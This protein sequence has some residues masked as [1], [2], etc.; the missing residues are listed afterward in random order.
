[1]QR[2]NKIL[3]AVLFLI[4]FA[5]LMHY[6]KHVVGPYPYSITERDLFC[7]SDKDCRL[8]Y[9]DCGGCC[10]SR[11]DVPVNSE[12]YDRITKWRKSCKSIPANFCDTVDCLSP[13]NYGFRLIPSCVNNSCIALKI[14][15][16]DQLCNIFKNLNSER[17]RRD[18]GAGIV[19]EFADDMDIS[20]EELNLWFEQCMCKDS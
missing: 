16:C 14:P 17:Y 10:M 19:K 13:F 1:M 9:L 11:N 7:E 12:T 18:H 3:L 6:T 5:G 4:I 8:T 20:V 15:D 2:A